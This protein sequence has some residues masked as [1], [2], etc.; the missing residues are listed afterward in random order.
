MTYLI[1]CGFI[2]IVL[3]LLALDLGVFNR[4]VHVIG[5][6]EALG[7][8]SFWIFLGLSFS[9]VVYYIYEHHWLDVGSSYSVD[10]VSG[11]K[12]LIEYITGYVIEKSLSLDNIFVIALIFEYFKIP[13]LYQHRVLFW[14]ILGALVLRGLMIS[15]GAVMISRFEW[16]VYVFGAFL[17]FTAIKMLISDHEK[18]EP[19][20]NPIYKLVKK[21]YAVSHKIEGM[22]FF[23]I[24]D[25]RKAVT[26]LLVALIIVESSDVLF[27]VDSIPAIFAVTKEPFIVFT[28][29]IFAILG[30]RSLYFALAAMIQKFK[31]LKISLVF[32]LAYV[33]IKM[34]LSHYYPIPSW[35]TLVFIAGILTIGILASII[36][37]NSEDGHKI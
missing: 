3:L 10:E 19:E 28:S 17:I 34:L 12:A 26:P 2:V 11:K 18:I 36:R 9:F 23:T 32:I 35:V 14:G 4:K 7:W 20:K 15:A 6:K 24:M 25:G 30:L 13:L 33:G 27:A 5:I 22:H 37:K 1:Y 31:Y 8:S 16:T 21:I 29:N